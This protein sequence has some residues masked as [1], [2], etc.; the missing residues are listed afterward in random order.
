ME[1]RHIAK[2]LRHD[3][4]KEIAVRKVAYGARKHLPRIREDIDLL[5]RLLQTYRKK[6]GTYHMKL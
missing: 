3:G 4:A 5:E 1:R 6:V 2:Y